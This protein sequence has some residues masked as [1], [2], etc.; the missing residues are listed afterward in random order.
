MAAKFYDSTTRTRR[1]AITAYERF[2]AE[3][4][5]SERADWVRERLADLKGEDK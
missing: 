3:H 1:S 4:P 2:L 5:Q